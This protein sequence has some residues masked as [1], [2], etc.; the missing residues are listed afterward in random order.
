MDQ[1]QINQIWNKTAN[2]INKFKRYDLE[3]RIQYVAKNAV[4]SELLASQIKETA[5]R[6]I[7]EKVKEQERQKEKQR[8][9]DAIIE[10]IQTAATNAV[11]ESVEV[12]K[13]ATNILDTASTN[14]NMINSIKDAAIKA[15]NDNVEEQKEQQE[16]KEKNYI[17]KQIETAAKNALTAE[18]IAS[19]I[20]ETAIRE[21]QKQVEEEQ[22]RLLLSKKMSEEKII[23]KNIET[24]AKDAVTSELM[25]SQIKETAI[26]SVQSQLKEVEEKE[27]EKIKN[28]AKQI[29]LNLIKKHLP[30]I[31]TIVAIKKAAI[32]AVKK[33]TDIESIEKHFLKLIDEFENAN[34]IM[35]DAKTKKDIDDAILKLTDIESQLKQSLESHNNMAKNITDKDIQNTALKKEIAIL[36]RINNANIKSQMPY[37]VQL[38]NELAALKQSNLQNELKNVAINKVLTSLPKVTEPK[39]HV[40]YLIEN[41]AINKVNDAVKDAVINDLKT[42]ITA[43]DLAL[44]NLIEAN[45]KRNLEEIAIKTVE[46]AT[47][48]SAKTA[49]GSSTGPNIENDLKNAAITALYR[50]LLGV[51]RKPIDIP[52]PQDKFDIR[53]TDKTYIYDEKGQPVEDTKLTKYDSILAKEQK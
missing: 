32:E 48:G 9:N 37:L 24:V 13:I 4:T 21:L 1:D 5:I 47:I 49:P 27:K 7:D 17:V 38:E 42:G 45:I 22:Q 2:L 25:A 3:K 41:A 6:T 53:I 33:N 50:A 18:L 40:K 14:E 35:N 10:N 46:R 11:K 12:F 30:L 26:Q 16:K 29:I 51:P 52:K 8:Q 15:I 44:K 39:I 19:Q 36:N 28:L 20:K 23:I 31:Q 43:K 34:K